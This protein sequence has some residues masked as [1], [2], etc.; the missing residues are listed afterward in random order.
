IAAHNDRVQRERRLREPLEVGG[1]LLGWRTAQR[2]GR[3]DEFGDRHRLGIGIGPQWGSPPRGIGDLHE[4]IVEG[5]ISMLREDRVEVGRLAER[6]DPKDRR[7]AACR[8]ALLAIGDLVRERQRR[9]EM[10]IHAAAALR[11][12]RRHPQE[13][14]VEEE[15]PLRL[16]RVEAGF[17]DTRRVDAIVDVDIDVGDGDRPDAHDDPPTSRVTRASTMSAYPA[18]TKSSAMTPAACFIARSI[19]RIGGGLT[20]SKTRKST[21]A[22]ACCQTPVPA[23]NSTT[24]NAA[25]SSITMLP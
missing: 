9:A 2:G 14:A 18:A 19:S 4:R 25:I 1:L 23:K 24:R 17:L 15:L 6:R 20:M 16:Q 13:P 7:Q 12:A 3:G 5:H 10:R 22:R 8:V 11:L 21:N